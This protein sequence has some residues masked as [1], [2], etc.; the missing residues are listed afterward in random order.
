[1]IRPCS[2]K[3]V[4]HIMGNETGYSL[5]NR[6]TRVVDL[7]SSLWL[8]MAIAFKIM[9]VCG[10]L[11]SPI[12]TFGNE[13][14][15]LFTF[16]ITNLIN[17]SLTCTDETKTRFGKGASLNSSDTFLFSAKLPKYSDIVQVN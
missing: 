17:V 1:M 14:Q 12:L 3:D 15:H 5:T 10:R 6:E 9:F 11:G 2:I 7:L 8:G 13:P 16:C 4:C